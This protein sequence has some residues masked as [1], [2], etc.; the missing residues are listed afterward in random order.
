MA[1][2]RKMDAIERLK[3][4][5]GRN[6]NRTFLVDSVSGEELKFAQLHRDA[7]KIGAYFHSKGYKKGDR[8]AFLLNNSFSFAKLYFGCLYSG[9]VVVPINPILSSLEIDFIIHHSKAGLVVVSDDTKDKINAAAAKKTNIEVLAEKSPLENHLNLS[10]LKEDKKFRP[11]LNMSKQD[12]LIIVYTSGTTAEPK[13]VVHRIADLVDNGY[14]FGASLG[15]GPN[16]RFYNIL[17][18]TY[19]GGYYNLFLLPYVCESSVVLAPAFNA[20]SVIDFWNPIIRNSVNTLWL[21]P[22]IMSILMELDRDKKGA[23]YCKDKIKTVLAG[24]APLPVRLRHDFEER[25]GKPVY[26][27]YGLTETLFISAN[28]AS[29]PLKDG[30]TGSILPGLKVKVVDGNSGEVPV[31]EEGEI[32]VQTPYLMRGY[33]NSETGVPDL[34]QPKDWF[35][36]G[37]LGFLTASKEIYITG[38]KKDLII[39]GGINISP[40]SIEDVIYKHPSVLECAAVGLPHKILGEDIVVVVRVKPSLDFETIRPELVKFCRERLSHIKQPTHIIGLK[41]FPRT[42]TGKIQKAKI[43]VWLKQKFSAIQAQT[44]P[45]KEK[46]AVSKVRKTIQFAPSK[47]VMESVQA[48]SIKYNTAV[49]EM[50]RKNIDV[51]VLSLGEA[52][53]D[54]PLFSFDNLPYP[55]SYHYSHSRGIPEL[56]ESLSKFFFSKYDV[57]FDYESEIIVTAGSKIAIHMALMSILNPGDEA[58]IYEPAWVSYPEQIKLCYAVPVRIPYYETISNFEKYITERTKVIIINNPNNPTGRVFN[59]EE[60]SN[61]YFLAEKYNLFILSDEAYSD[62]LLDD[63]EFISL[64]NLDREKKH[65]IICNS[66]SKN[67]GI[68]GWR[69]GYVVANSSLINEILKVNQ[70]LITCPATILE[71]YIAKHF[72]KIAQITR[73]QIMNVVRQRQA[74]AQY[75]DK[76]GLKYLPGSATFYFFVSIEDSMLASEEFCTRLLLDEHISVVPGIGYGKSCDKFIRVSVG[77]ESPERIRKGLKKVKE[78]TDKT[79]VKNI[80]SNYEYA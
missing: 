14:L 42:S 60:L 50:K 32:L 75:M 69:L 66:I 4:I 45:P 36:T 43:R 63:K 76:I 58:I 56:R 54:I 12:D 57:L 17:P 23:N 47:V 5:P 24:T 9:M 44:V 20:S 78:L 2:G 41:E 80:P 67:F 18:M 74:I 77:T 7:C 25:Y 72:F 33:Y 21:V 31:G 34:I 35:A 52:F 1:Q 29:S 37:D 26:E 16:N 79:S 65:T 27:N 40:V 15:I 51:I 30:S 68:S 64:G 49:Y 70:H 3:N 10:G 13:G 28:S 53:F 39:R 48:M 71:H 61:L 59:L 55:G 62:F 8:V 46:Q 6:V 11:F 38:R 22:T 73:P 19:L